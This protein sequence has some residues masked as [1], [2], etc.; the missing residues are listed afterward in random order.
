ME[1]QAQLVEAGDELFVEADVKKRKKKR[2]SRVADAASLEMTQDTRHVRFHDEEEQTEERPA[3]SR[4]LRPSHSVEASTPQ[5]D[6][7]HVREA[8]PGARHLV[9][10][11]QDVQ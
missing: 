1:P 7:Q 6:A 2:R 10:G 8:H 5:L 4:A 3:R 9:Q 11:L